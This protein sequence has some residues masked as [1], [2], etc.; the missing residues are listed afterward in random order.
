M[1][2]GED[3]DMLQGTVTRSGWQISDS[4][5]EIRSTIVYPTRKHRRYGTQSTTNMFSYTVNPTDNTREENV[6]SH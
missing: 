3:R 4:E 6:V 2:F 1:G 5:P